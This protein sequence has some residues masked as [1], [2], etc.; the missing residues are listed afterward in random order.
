MMNI[1]LTL[2]RS[3]ARQT[4]RGVEMRR[5]HH[6]VPGEQRREHRH[7]GGAV[8]ER[9]RAEPDQPGRLQA[10]AGLLPLVGQRD[11]G[12]EVDAAGER[13][14]DVLVPPHDAL[15]ISGRP[16]G[17]DDVDVIVA[18]RREIAGGRGGGQRGRIPGSAAGV[19]VAAVLD[20]H[21]AAQPGGGPR[22][23]GGPR[24]ELPV[25]DERGE[26][27][28]R[29]HVLQLVLGVPVVDVDRDRAELARRDQRLGG[30]D[31]VAR[32]EPDVAPAPR[33]PI[34]ARWW[35]SRL[36]RSSSSR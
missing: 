5:Q 25:A 27:G 13:A 6:G 20:H 33:R 2:C 14:P 22:H 11:T 31:G 1:R 28:V 21:D 4:S 29:E 26:V 19:G 15:G 8:D 34:P 9:C 32:V 17:V 30:L 10:A 3:T 16:A 23:R 24:R 18:A 12:H 36:V 35:A 7:L